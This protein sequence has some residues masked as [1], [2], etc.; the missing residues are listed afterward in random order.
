MVKKLLNTNSGNTKIKKTEKAAAVQFAEWLQQSTGIKKPVRM[1]ELSLYPD[2]I[3]C[4]YSTIA[5]CLFGCLKSSG[6]GRFDNVKRARQAKSEYW[7]NNRAAF[8]QQLTAELS[9]FDK[10]CKKTGKQ[11][12]IR[13]NVISDIP[14]EKYGIPQKFP[15]L[16]FYD[17]TKNSSRLG[18]TPANYKL[19]FSYSGAPEYQKYLAKVPETTPLAVVF[20]G[21]LPQFFNGKPVIDGDKSDLVN[22]FAENKIVGLLAKGAAKKDTGNFTIDNRAGNI[23]INQAF[24][25]L[26]AEA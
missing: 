11:G 6:R 20:K 17:Y 21:Q 25:V 5:D 12:V 14:F 22:A 1:A 24:N 10:L 23:S 9:R 13:L 16:F 3:I 8:L 26:T 18:K 19:I 4:P 15:D 7:H 2:S